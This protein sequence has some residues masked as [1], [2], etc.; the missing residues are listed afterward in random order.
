[1]ARFTDSERPAA[2][3]AKVL[4][5]ADIL[6]IS[7]GCTSG[8]FSDQSTCEANGE[9]WTD[10]ILLTTYVSDLPADVGNGEEV[11]QASGDL[12]SMSDVEESLTMDLGTVSLGMM[13]ISN[14]WLKLSQTIELNGRDVEIWRVLLDPITREIINAPFK[15]FAGT[16]VSGQ[17]DKKNIKDGSSVELE[18]SN[19][20]YNFQV[21]SGFR[22]N[23]NDHQKFF[24]NDTGFKDTS[25]VPRKLGWGG[26]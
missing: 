3:K 12:L 2:L 23:T 8:D 21:L 16:V 18:V 20:F 14:E 5:S 9:L 25:S 10:D 1:M 26:V 17:V 6:K 11:F 7:F 4:I 13:A 22:C 24:P 15:Y 19:H